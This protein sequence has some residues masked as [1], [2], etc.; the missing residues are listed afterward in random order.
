MNVQVGTNLYGVGIGNH[1]QA[2]EIP[3]VSSRA[4]RTTDT[5]FPVGKRWIQANVAEFVLLGFTRV[6]SALNATWVQTSTISTFPITPFVVGPIGQAGYQTIQSA[7]DAANAAGGGM[8]FVQFGTYNENLTFYNNIQ[9]FGDSEQGTFIIGTHTPPTTGTLNIFRVTMEGASAIFSSAAAGS[10]AIIVEDCTLNV[11][12][13]YS[14]D[15]P[16]WTSAGSIAIDDIGPFGANDGGIRNTG[17]AGFFVFA[18]GFGDGTVNPMIL[19]GFSEFLASSFGCPINFVT[20]ASFE[21][22]DCFFTGPL[23]FLN[24]STGAITNSRISSGALAAVTMSSS[25][26]IGLNNCVIDS[27][28]NPSIDGTGAG[29][30]TLNDIVWLNNSTV[31]GT[32]TLGGTSLTP[33]T[34]TALSSGTLS[35]KSTSAN[36]GDNAGFI[37]VLLNGSTVFVP[38][39]TNIAP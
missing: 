31:A 12:N 9:L 35:I 37:E 16:N 4:P 7:L 32:L 39:Y 2:V 10:A 5:K 36:P 26:S 21:I 20:G 25:G 15:L 14:F 8:V 28:N 19:S 27:T 22:D 1:P 3:F 17:G 11:F 6:S 18:A 13:G 24:N 38:Y 34:N 33:N 23:T 30:L 29:I